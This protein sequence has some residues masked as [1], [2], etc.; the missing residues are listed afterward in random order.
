MK[1][2]THEGKIEEHSFDEE[3]GRNSLRHTA[4]HILAQAV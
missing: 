4:S 3:L 1:V 2:I